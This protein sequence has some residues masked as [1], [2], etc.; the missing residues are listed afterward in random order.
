MDI[1]DV[2][3]QGWTLLLY[4]IT[5]SSPRLFSLTLYS[6]TNE[7]SLKSSSIQ[8]FPQLPSDLFA[9]LK[10][11][12]WN[13][14]I[15]TRALHPLNWSDSSALLQQGAPESG[16]WLVTNNTTYVIAA[17]RVTTQLTAGSVALSV[18]FWFYLV[19]LFFFY[20]RLQSLAEL[21]CCRSSRGISL[22]LGLS[23]WPL[24]CPAVHI[25]R[26][27]RKTAG[28]LSD[29]LLQFSFEKPSWHKLLM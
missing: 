26:R 21:V 17:V 29:W 12:K 20:S 25:G 15:W 27:E 24:D 28:R 18:S 7:I 3:L 22:T 11:A 16:Y 14:M 19:L 13:I 10:H 1:G 23:R 6:T 4:Q 8:A 5:H 2:S 9:S